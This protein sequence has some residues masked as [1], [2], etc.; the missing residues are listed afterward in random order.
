MRSRSET[1]S[2]SLTTGTVTF[3]EIVPVSPSSSETVRLRAD[4]EIAGRE[5]VVPGEIVDV[6]G[7]GCRVELKQPVGRGKSLDGAVRPLPQN[8]LIAGVDDLEV[9]PVEGVEDI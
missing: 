5:G 7:S 9:P 3:C 6:S 4:A 8:E 1:W 2:E